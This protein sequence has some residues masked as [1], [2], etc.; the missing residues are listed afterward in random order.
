[1]KIILERKI[2]SKEN[3]SENLKHYLENNEHAFSLVIHI[4][5][6]QKNHTENNLY[7]EML[8]IND[9]TLIGEAE[10]DANLDLEVEN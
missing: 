9:L 8:A 5:E 3:I 7:N 1:M 4:R 6:E 10:T 2:L